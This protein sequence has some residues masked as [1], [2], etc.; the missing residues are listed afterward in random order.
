VLTGREA[1]LVARHAA[2]YPGQA[3]PTCDLAKAMQ[4]ST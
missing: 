2:E 4:A 3:E 1:L